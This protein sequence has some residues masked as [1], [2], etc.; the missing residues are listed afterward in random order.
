MKKIASTKT[1]RTNVHF[2]EREDFIA[3]MTEAMLKGPVGRISEY[4][5]ARRRVLASDAAYVVFKVNELTRDFT[6]VI[7]KSVTIR[8]SVA[9]PSTPARLSLFHFL[10]SRGDH[11]A[12]HTVE[13][14]VRAT[15]EDVARGAVYTLLA[16]D[17]KT[18]M[19]V[20]S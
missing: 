13:V 8:N 11:T 15:D 1:K 16:A 4:A 7:P 3:G 17:E 18:A 6:L 5:A 20:A 19:E 2:I 9:T 14:D 10:V 12:E